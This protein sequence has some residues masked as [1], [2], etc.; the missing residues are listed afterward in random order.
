MMKRSEDYV[1]IGKV[2]KPHGVKGE[3]RITPFSGDTERLASYQTLFLAPDKK[4][5]KRQEYNLLKGYS[6]E[7]CA[8]V[9]LSG[10]DNRSDAEQV[11]DY[12][13]W[14]AR[15]DLPVLSDSE[16][17]WHD[18]EGKEVFTWQ[19]AYLGQV[20]NLISNGLHDIIVISGES[21]REYMIPV[22]DDFVQGPDEKKGGIVV[23]PPEGLLD[24]NE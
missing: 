7:G 1:L 15:E 6:Q 3:I 21:G 12:N 5:E 16:F 11:R 10:I 24:I 8:I 22:F 23:S 4:D 17:Y 19:G 20:R 9:F 18:F 2:G 13:V 14:L